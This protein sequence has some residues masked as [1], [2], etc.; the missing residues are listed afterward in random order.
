MLKPEDKE[1]QTVSQE[2]P[3]N[4]IKEKLFRQGGSRRIALKLTIVLSAV[5][6]A[7]F[8]LPASFIERFYARGFYPRLQSF[9]TP[10]TNRLPFAIYD[11]LIITLLTGIPTWWTVRLVKAG[12][13]RRWRA[14]A[15][16]FGDTLVLAA[17]S[18]LLFQLLWGFHYMR[19]PLTEK[20]DYDVARINEEAALRL[21][22]ATVERLNAEAEAAHQSL[23]PDDEEWRRRL[24]PSYKVLAREFGRPNDI[25]LAKAKA[26]LFDKY[27]EAAGITGFIN[28]FGHETIVG[29]GYHSL[30][31]AFTLAHEWGHLSGFAEESEAS[32]IGLLALL[33]S[34]DAAC[35]YAGWLA[36]YS[37]LPLRSLKEKLEADNR[38]MPKLASLVEDDLRAMDEEAARR[39]TVQSVSQAQWQMY[40]QFLKVHHT[41]ASYGELISLVMGTEFQEGWVPVH[42]SAP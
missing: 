41:T 18:F 32:F 26:T 21:Y 24:Q 22:G 31:R 25:T 34:D 14:T 37:H 3:I 33:R 9:A 39:H 2:K 11:L 20:L 6:L 30:D 27:L 29:R 13:G 17:I 8:Q 40:D 38:K 28:P 1:R 36:V 42:R 12:K 10:I 19:K 5:L 15:K 23:W 7:I 16:L 4:F 35:R